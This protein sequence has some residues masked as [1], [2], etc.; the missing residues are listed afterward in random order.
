MFVWTIKN[1]TSYQSTKFIHGQILGDLVSDPEVGG[2]GG[3]TWALSSESP[4]GQALYDLPS[5]R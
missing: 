5:L 2:G 4:Y 1:A 3:G